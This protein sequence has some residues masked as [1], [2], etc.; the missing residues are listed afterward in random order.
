MKHDQQHTYGKG[1]DHEKHHHARRRYVE[2][3]LAGA[4]E[5]GLKA[6]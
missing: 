2:N 4:A 5:E 1:E 3:I 6:E